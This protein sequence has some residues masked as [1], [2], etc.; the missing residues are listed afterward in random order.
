M[1]NDDNNN[2]AKVTD[3]GYGRMYQGSPS[4]IVMSIAQELIQVLEG[5]GVKPT[6]VHLIALLHVVTS[7]IHNGRKEWENGDTS[8]GQ[9]P[10][11][12]TLLSFITRT[13]R[14]QQFTPEEAK[15]FGTEFIEVIK[16]LGGEVIPTVE[17][18]QLPKDAQM[19]M[20]P[21]SKEIH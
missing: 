19:V 1:S 4:N 8:L 12:K 13:T 17:A 20:A 10:S 14:G 21:L 7:A 3:L 5:A 15:A 9:M 18:Q 11:Y 2:R 16:S 6:G